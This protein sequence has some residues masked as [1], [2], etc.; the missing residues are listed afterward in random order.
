MQAASFL[1]PETAF[2]VRDEIGTPCYVYDEASLRSVAAKVSDFPNAFGLTARFAM[3]ACP[4]ANI[5]RL[6]KSIGLKIDASSIYE[7][8]RAVAAGFDASD[9]SLS[10]QEFPTDDRLLSLVA[11]GMM[12]NACSLHQLER[13]GMLFPNAKVGLRF[14]P[15]LGSGGTQ[16]TNVGGP[17]SSFGIWFEDIDKVKKIVSGHGLEVFRIHTHIGSGSDPEV[18]VKAVGLSLNLVRSFDAVTVLNLGGGYKVGRMPDEE[19]T[20]LQAIGA[21]MRE[22]FERFQSE[23][24]RKLHLEIEP[25]TY[26][27]ANSCVLIST[28][29]DLTSTGEDGYDFIKLDTG[30]TENVRPSM[31]GAQHPMELLAFDGDT[32]EA[33]T[34]VI[35]GHCCESGDILTPAPGD[36]E[37]LLPRKLVDAKIGDILAIGGAGAYCAA[38]STKNYNSFPE[39]PEVMLR[40]DGSLSV[41]RKRQTLE[42]ILANETEISF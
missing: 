15:G 5:L 3:K 41:M 8:E 40:L 28:V 24:G 30:M 35:T 2:R 33:H 42:Q 14:N 32:R 19:T 23:T 22:A 39:C 9:I 13:Y 25:G 11:K 10:T 31:Y 7:A 26:L 4:N 27:M 18:W 20:D 36:A 38:M 37:A 17:A 1:N 34:Y 21:P 6:F 12:V 29:Q 16:R